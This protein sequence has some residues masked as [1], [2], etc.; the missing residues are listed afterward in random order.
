MRQEEEQAMA[1]ALSGIGVNIPTAEST[2]VN[3]VQN[4]P[5]ASVEE[6]AALIQRT[7]ADL[8]SVANTL[9]VPV[10]NAQKAYDAAISTQSEAQS[11]AN[12]AQAAATD[13]AKKEIADTVVADKTGLENVMDYMASG[14]AT[15]DQDI[16]REIIK[17][18][19][20][21]GQLA[22]ALNVPVDEATIRYTR[23][24]E[25]AQIEDIA[26][27]GL[28]KAKADF[29]NGIPD[30]LLKRYAAE[31][32]D[33]AE[34]IAG[35]MDNL[36]LTVDDMAR[37]TGIPLAE[38]Q[39]AYNAAKGSTG[40]AAVT[41]GTEVAGGTGAGVTSGTGSVASPTAVAGAAGTG[42]QTGLAGAERALAGGVTAAAQAIESGAGQARSDI[43]GGT[44]IARQ[45][46]A[47]GAQ[48]AGQ[49]IQSGTGLGLN[50]LGTGLG[51][52][53][54][55]ILGGSQAGLGALYQGLGGARTD[56]QAAQ[57]AANRQYSAG[58]GDVTAARDLASQQVGQAFGQA[59]QMLDP[60]RQAGTAALQ[61]QAA[62]SGALG[63]EAFN[64]AFQASPQQ[65]FLRE[66]GERAAL[67]TAA[68]RGG[69]GGGNVMKEL[70]R[71][72]T[73]LAS[74]DLQNQ[75]ANLQALGSQGLGASGTAGQLAA[76]GAITQ[77][78]IQRQA[79]QQ[80]ADQRNLM[81][82]SQLGTGQQLAGLGTL[83]G[84]QGLSTLTGAGQQLGQL[85]VTGGTEG[86]R[87]L[88]GAGSQLSD[89][90]SGRSL[91]QSQLASQ[92]GRQLGDISLTGGMTVGDYLYGTGGALAQNRM[93]AGRD[94]AGNITNQIN[95][96][97]QYQG[98]QG[99]GMSDL[100]GQQANILAGIQGGAGAGMSGMI[101][102]TAGQLAGVATGTGAAYDPSGL[103]QT[104]QV[105]GMLG[106]SG[107]AGLSG[108]IG[109]MLPNGGG[110]AAG[111]LGGIQGGTAA[112]AALSD[113][114]LKENIKRV[115]TTSRG[116]GWYNWDWNE[117]GQSIA[118]DQP[119][120]GV[121][122]QEVAEID[123]SA[124][125]IGDDGYLRVDYL[126]V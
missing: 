96:L 52:A 125:I 112:L 93:Q 6:V 88:T 68:A 63:Q 65:Q 86:M 45:D 85:G 8:S 97:A 83:A 51:A 98:D 3:F 19:V 69:V 87:A 57:E 42:G 12:V 102:G 11:A 41:G 33:S 70:S 4:N 15:N 28:E 115:G 108:A 27:G 50:A 60:Y 79:A 5:N 36:G 46:L 34:Q 81:A 71:F 94:I 53:R 32:T 31:T 123:P 76:Q 82:S 91:A 74:Q 110:A 62:L 109:G 111:A 89:I 39:T 17:Q 61:Q 2:V 7:G 66:Q 30:N 16:Y 20:D 29:P 120:Y 48:E 116:H 77:A 67:R 104:S 58:L 1:E 72:N 23:A 80:V 106:S 124:I 101:G 40:G 38:V 113:V 84:Q 64:Q 119:S 114:R 25:L 13:A 43:L 100:I 107:Q 26:R 55:D 73:G 75:I 118:K 78:D 49:M 122:A 22:A 35:Y 9:G 90:A 21:V 95:A 44:Q 37:A 24:Q 121:L 59:G 126:K 47:Q 92:A 10:A 117:K 56:L 105:S 54:R 14:Q 103:G 99:I 18:G